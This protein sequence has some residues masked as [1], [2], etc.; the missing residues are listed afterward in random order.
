MSD[1]KD[2]LAKHAQKRRDFL[3]K[4]GKA[5]V[6]A[7]AVALLLQAGIKP[8]YADGYGGGGGGGGGATTTT[9]GGATTTTTTSPFT[10]TGH[11]PI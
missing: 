8:A 4:S 1:E 6:A 3:K 5:A 7:P 11:S 2:T 9:T 10:T